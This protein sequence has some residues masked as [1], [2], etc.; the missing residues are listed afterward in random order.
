[1]LRP[2]NPIASGKKV[3]C[4]KCSTVFVA[5]EDEVDEL[6]ELDEEEERPRKKPA[7]QATPARGGKKPAPAVKAKEPPKKKDDEVETYGYVKDN[8]DDED[9]KPVVNYAPD[10]SV[11]DL[12]GP[13]IVKLTKPATLLQ[14]VGFLAALGTFLFALLLIIPEAF[15]IKPDDP[16]PGMAPPPGEK[17]GKKPAVKIPVY[18]I[19]GYDLKELFEVPWYFFLMWMAVLAALAFYSAIVVASGVKMQNLESR[20]WSITGSVMAILPINVIGFACLAALLV[21]YT[22]GYLMEDEEFAYTVSLGAAAALWLASASLGG[23]ALKVLM[24]E[25]VIAGFEYDPE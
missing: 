11:K 9:D 16:K 12:R 20:R 18:K 23:N 7:R 15:P 8:E 10:M 6:E 2:A 22:F 19:F 17:D 13:A 24:D 5:G 14:L 3:K 25:T 21:Q 4:P 1:M